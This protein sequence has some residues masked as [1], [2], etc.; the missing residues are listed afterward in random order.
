MKMHKRVYVCRVLSIPT[1]TE[2]GA[3]NIQEVEA[4]NDY[5]RIQET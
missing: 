3:N 2:E 5:S 1:I 4:A